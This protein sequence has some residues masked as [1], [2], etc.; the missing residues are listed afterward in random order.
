MERVGEEEFF[1]INNLT[2]I[3]NE[4]YEQFARSL[5]QE[6]LE[7][8]KDRPLT[9]T[10]ENIKGLKLKDREIDELLANKIVI[11]FAMNGYIDENFQLTE[12]VIED[13]EKGE[14]QLPEELKEYQEEI[15]NIVAKINAS[16]I[17]KNVIS[18]EKAVNIK[19]DKL[20][21]NENFK[22]FQKFWEKI[23]FKTAYK[24]SFDSEEL[25]QKVV[26]RIDKELSIKRIRIDVVEL[27]Q[28]ERLRP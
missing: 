1:E 3:A 10:V 9:F 28:R 17:F 26:A 5:Q 15:V 22:R 14:L 2:V 24:I 18:D 20:E 8:I 16:T 11:S 27:E 25:I 19:L 21:P 6:Y 23:K 7:T 4:S 12:K 13:I